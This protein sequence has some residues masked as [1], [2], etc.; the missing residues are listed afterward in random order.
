[1]IKETIILGSFLLI[2]GY[3]IGIKKATWLLAGYNEKRV[4][5]KDKLAAIVGITYAIL[6][7]IL[8]LTGLL[9]LPFAE[10]FA[11]IAVGIIV[12]QIIYV[13]IKMVH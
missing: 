11:L 8:L 12:L 10:L 13:Q 1:M 4:L 7:A 9:G 6:G 5:D 3:L 2:S